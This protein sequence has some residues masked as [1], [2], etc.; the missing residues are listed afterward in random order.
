MLN[1]DVTPRKVPQCAIYTLP[2][3]KHFHIGVS[4][5][6]TS[7]LPLSGC[8]VESILIHA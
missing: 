6:H 5:G 1:K 7:K 2:F 4:L 8:K 3:R